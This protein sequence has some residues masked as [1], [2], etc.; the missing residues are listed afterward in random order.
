MCSPSR[1]CYY[2][3]NLVA[4]NIFVPWYRQTQA[5]DMKIALLDSLLPKQKKA[6]FIPKQGSSIQ[7]Y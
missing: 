5:V 7:Y 4:L 2:K 3:C 1:K 6:L